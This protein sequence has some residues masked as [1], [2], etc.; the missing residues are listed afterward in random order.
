MSVTPNPAAH[1]PNPPQVVLGTV[2]REY[3]S[4][5]FSADGAWLYGGTT[6]ADV[7]TVN[8]Q[9]ASVQVCVG[10]RRGRGRG[11]GQ[12]WGRR[13][14]RRRGAEARGGGAGKG[15]RRVG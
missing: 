7:V 5:A 12:G 8:V 13:P 1:L 15:L 14:G 3:T 11:R 2:R 9:R 10:G 6:S 4:L